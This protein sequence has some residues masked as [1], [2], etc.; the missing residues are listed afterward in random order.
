M[1]MLYLWSAKYVLGLVAAGL[2]YSKMFRLSVFFI[3]LMQKLNM[4]KSKGPTIFFSLKLFNIY[5]EW[6]NYY[7]ELGAAVAI[8][9]R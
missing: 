1:Y 3:I 4:S 9:V 6:P 7:F 8:M 2:L 5:R